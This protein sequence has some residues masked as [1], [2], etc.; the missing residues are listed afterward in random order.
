MKVNLVYNHGL[1]LSW[2]YKTILTAEQSDDIG[3]DRGM[4][5]QPI[6]DNLADGC[7]AESGRLGQRQGTIALWDSMVV[8]GSQRLV[9]ETLNLIS[10]TLSVTKGT[11]PDDGYGK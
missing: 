5:A 8:L 2:Y 9:D 11:C 10:I 3:R 4:S 6:L 7:L 1:P